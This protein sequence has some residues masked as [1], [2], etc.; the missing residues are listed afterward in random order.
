MS[1]CAAVGVVAVAPPIDL[2]RP[3]GLL[4]PEAPLRGLSTAS[5]VRAGP[6][7][8]WGGAGVLAPVGPRIRASAGIPELRTSAV[9]LQEATGAAAA[10]GEAPGLAQ[11]SRAC[12][13]RA[14]GICAKRREVRIRA[15]FLCAKVDRLCNARGQVPDD[16]VV[17]A[18]AVCGV[19]AAAAWARLPAA[20]ASVRGCP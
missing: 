3:S 10:G 2:A 18:G 15:S 12:F 6:A 1:A 11:R 8:G 17:S 19:T 7:V 9:V 5:P 4:C 16:A 13:L 14:G 20:E